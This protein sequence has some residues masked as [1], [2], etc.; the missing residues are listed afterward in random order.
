M[1]SGAVNALCI[2]EGILIT[3]ANDKTIKFFKSET[4][5]VLA[6]I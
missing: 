1:H 2:H 4:L 5:E 6:S 3:G